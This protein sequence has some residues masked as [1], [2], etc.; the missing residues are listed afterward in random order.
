MNVKENLSSSSVQLWHKCWDI[1]I[2][3]SEHEICLGIWAGGDEIVFEVTYS[4]GKRLWRWIFTYDSQEQHI[5]FNIVDNLSIDLW[6]ANFKSSGRSVKLDLT[7]D[8]NAFISHTL[9]TESLFLIRPAEVNT[10]ALKSKDLNGLADVLSLLE[11][12]STQEEDD[13]EDEEVGIRSRGKCYSRR[14]CGGRAYSRRYN[15]C[16][17]CK[18][19]GGKSKTDQHGNCH[20]C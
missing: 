17:N 3:G 15:H 6:M 12:G 18:Q 14:N 11:S 20:N 4:I 5:V 19:R 1:E 9:G 2:L 13:F 16:H 7:I 8:F 10:K